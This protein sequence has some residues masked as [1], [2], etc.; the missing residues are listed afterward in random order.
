[1]VL[2]VEVVSPDSEN[3][4][5]ARKPQLYAEAGIPHFWR[6]GDSSGRITVYVYG[7]DHRRP[8]GR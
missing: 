3:R 7:L 1:V 5:R 2:A 6:I 4:D 8:S